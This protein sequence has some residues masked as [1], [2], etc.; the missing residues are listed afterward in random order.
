MYRVRI[1]GSCGQKLPLSG[2][3]LD[4][5]ARFGVRSVCKTC[6]QERA[7]RWRQ[8]NPERKAEQ[9]R[10]YLERINADPERLELRRAKRRAYD[11]MRKEQ[12]LRRRS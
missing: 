3:Y 2:F 5:A 10:L 4:S 9:N 6:D 12:E 8:A 7:R 1:C 11:Q